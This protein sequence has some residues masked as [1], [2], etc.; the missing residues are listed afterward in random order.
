MERGGRVGLSLV[1]HINR[2][3]KIKHCIYM[4]Q[5]SSHPSLVFIESQNGVT[6]IQKHGL[7]VKGESVYRLISVPVVFLKLIPILAAILLS[8][9]WKQTA[10]LLLPT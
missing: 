10:S 3:Q 6:V 4:H 1:R 7:E 5:T 2:L 9:L 8:F